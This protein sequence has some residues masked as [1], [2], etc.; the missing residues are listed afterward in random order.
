M[1]VKLAA[2]D[3]L[4]FSVVEQHIPPRFNPPPVHHRQTRE[5]AAV[6]VLEGELRYWLR[7]EKVAAPAGTLV[8]LPR[9]TWWRWANESDAPCRVLAI[10]APAGFERYFLELTE[11]IASSDPQSATDTFARLRAL[12]GDEERAD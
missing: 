10:F 3:G 2:A 7:D 11:A 1:E 8:H 9:L 6:Y 5:D 12:Y 4:G